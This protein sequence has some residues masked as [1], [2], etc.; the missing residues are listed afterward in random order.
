MFTGII[1]TT[2]VISTISTSGSNRTFQ[3]I[4]AL[5]PDLKVDQ[6]LSHDGVCLTVESMTEHTYQVTAI[7]ETLSKTNLSGWRPGGRVNLERCLQI[8]GRLD[9][10]MVQ[11]HVDATAIC[12]ERRDDQG[13]WPVRN[14]YLKKDLREEI[15]RLIDLEVIFCSFRL[16]SQERIKLVEIDGR[17][18]TPN[19]ASRYRKNWS[20]S[21]PYASTVWAEYLFSNFR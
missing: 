1:E 14:W 21:S 9:G 16:A 10:H 11:G 5:S 20:R 6:S 7:A 3:I 2:G 4:S 15:F 18:A 12:L 19:W 8:N 17:S 13:S